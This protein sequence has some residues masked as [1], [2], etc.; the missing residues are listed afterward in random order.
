M[1]RPC[2]FLLCNGRTCCPDRGPSHMHTPLADTPS[3]SIFIRCQPW[4]PNLRRS[5]DEMR[6]R[7]NRE[8]ESP[9]GSPETRLVDYPVRV[10]PGSSALVE[11]AEPVQGGYLDVLKGARHGPP[12]AKH[13]GV[14]INLLADTPASR[15]LL[16]SSTRAEETLPATRRA[17]R[18][19]RPTWCWIS[20]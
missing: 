9:P 6:S 13:Y 20:S 5:L 1:N 18:S 3:M 11:P 16:A 12:V 15:T 8:A 19:L 2:G 17:P 7:V 14:T 4:S 10:R